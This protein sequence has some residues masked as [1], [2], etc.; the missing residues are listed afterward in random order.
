[1]KI[2]ESLKYLFTNYHVINKDFINYNIEIKIWNNKKMN[3][4]LNH[5]YIRYFEKP[6]DVTII[7]IKEEDK[8]YK[9]I[10]F[11]D[12]DSNYKDKGYSIYE[13]E[14]VFTLEH[15]SGDDVSC[16]SGKIL[17][18]DNYEFTHNIST[19]TG[20]SGCPII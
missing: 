9:D 13:N 4:N 10:K 7:E 1:M 12:Y 16:A 20:S 18:I 6:E 3:I 11:L 17:N 8:I 2:S 5:R 19:E 15:P 14:D